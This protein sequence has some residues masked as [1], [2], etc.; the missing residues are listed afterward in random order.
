MDIMIIYLLW[1]RALDA[2]RKEMEKEWGRILGEH[3]TGPYDDNSYMVS[4]QNFNFSKEVTFKVTFEEK[5]EMIIE[6][7]TVFIDFPK[8]VLERM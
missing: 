5:M 2:V 4:V 3:W 1:Y 6:G 7:K 8:A